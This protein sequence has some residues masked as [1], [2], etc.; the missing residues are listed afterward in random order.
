MKLLIDTSK[1]P[2]IILSVVDQEKEIARIEFEAK[3]SQAEKLLPAIDDLLKNS[4]LSLSDIREVFVK[5]SGDSFTSL[6]I[7][8]VTANSLA[9][10]LGIPV[11]NEEGKNIKV[12]NISIVKPKYSQEPHITQPKK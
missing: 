2:N 10:G 5:D 6:R 9:Y 8:I 1:S 12:E 7:G 4:E 11:A 3:H